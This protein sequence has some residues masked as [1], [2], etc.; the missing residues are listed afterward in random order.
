MT[1]ESTAAHGAPEPAAV[2]ALDKAV[3]SNSPDILTAAAADPGLN[4]DLALA[5]LKR[6]DLPA[7]VI[8]QLT[9][10]AALK[11]SRKLRV[12]VVNHPKAPR[13]V[14]LPI[15]RQL[16]TFDLM[17]VA[18]TPVVPADLK[19][20]AD[21]ALV[22]RLETI[23]IG[24]K[25]SLARRASA[26]V[27]GALLL[28]AE[29]RVMR[30][31][32]DNSRLSESSIVKA[33]MRPEASAAFVDAVCRHRKWCLRREVKIALLRNEKTP[34]ARALELARDFPPAQLRTI[35]ESSRLCATAKSR[36]LQEL[37]KRTREA[38]H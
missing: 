36:L 37:Q 6:P 19:L 38:L 2:P 28:D 30:A 27:A 10:N 26:R 3:Q 1:T 8:E 21:D 23:S 29:T 16:F 17:Q 7:D 35:L 31:A 4:E 9:K 32:L 12:A 15:V 13:H 25:L 20:A 34:T 24:E 22:S 11:K 14:S 33:I 18:L 5:L